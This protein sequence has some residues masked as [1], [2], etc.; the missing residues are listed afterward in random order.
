MTVSLHGDGRATPE[1]AAL[2]VWGPRFSYRDRY[3]PRLYRS[4]VAAGG[5]SDDE[6]Q[7]RSTSSSAIWPC[8]KAC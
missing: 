7:A 3:L 6:R 5:A 4:P 2:R 1:L 8:S